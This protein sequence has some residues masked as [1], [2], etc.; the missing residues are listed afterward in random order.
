MLIQHRCNEPINNVS[1][2][3]QRHVEPY[4]HVQ[5]LSFE[6]F[7]NHRRLSYYHGLCADSQ[8]KS[9]NQKQ[10][11]EFPVAPQSEDKLAQTERQAENVQS[12]SD[13]D[14]VEQNSTEDREHDVGDGK[15]RVKH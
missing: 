10:V 4:S 9:A 8:D 14:F 6:P 2:P 12:G 3:A 13:A 1:H 15:E 5:F 7:G 11:E